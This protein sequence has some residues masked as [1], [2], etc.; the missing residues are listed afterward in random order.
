MESLDPASD[1]LNTHGSY[2]YWVGDQ[3]VKAKINLHNPLKESSAEQD[4]M[5]DLTVAVGEPNLEISDNS[6]SGTGPGI[7]GFGLNFDDGFERSMVNSLGQLSEIEDLQGS[8]SEK[9]TQSSVSLSLFNNGFIRSP[10][11]CSHWRP[12]A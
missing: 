4:Q 3:G 10:F 2:A 7:G 9:K 1:S 11:G 6:D 8:E 5:D 12:K